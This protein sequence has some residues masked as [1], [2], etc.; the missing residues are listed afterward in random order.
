MSQVLV[1][2]LASLVLVLVLVL[3]LAGLVLVLVLACP[4]LVSLLTSPLKAGLQSLHKAKDDAIQRLENMAITTLTN[5]TEQTRSTYVFCI[6]YL[7]YILI[8]FCI[9]YSDFTYPA[10]LYFTVHKIR[11]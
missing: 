1:L 4:V 3:V 11:Y 8:M 10:I 5:E 2:V 7:K 9:L 6:L